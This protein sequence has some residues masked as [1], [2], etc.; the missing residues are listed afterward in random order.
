MLC[1]QLTIHY[2][3]FVASF[4]SYWLIK[5]LPFWG[6][7]LLATSITFLGPLVYLQNQQFIDEH[8]N[9]A[10]TVINAQATQVRDLAAEHTN[11]A[12]ESVRSYAGEYTQKAQEMIGQARGRTTGSPDPVV[13][14]TDLPSAPKQA[15]LPNAPH[16]EPVGAPAAFKA[17]PTLAH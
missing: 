3:A 5:W 1:T 16:H 17:E 2:Q 11:R 13:K 4:V 7:S 12:T 15:P 6:L 10:G 14:S 9:H 8:I